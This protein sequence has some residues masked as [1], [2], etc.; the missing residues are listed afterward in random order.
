MVQFFNCFEVPAGRED[1]F[2]GLWQEVNA[3]MITKP[4]YEGHAL[5]RS[6]RPDATFRFLNHGVWRSAEDWAAAHD[7][8][9]REML[10]RPQWRAFRSTPALYEPVH[11]G[12]VALAAHTDA[13][14]VA[15][16]VAAGDSVG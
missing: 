5:H 4:G 2:F 10:S 9:F 6:L 11:T 16:G 8:G 7:A 14:G 1:E 12:P 15:A 3:Y 13:A